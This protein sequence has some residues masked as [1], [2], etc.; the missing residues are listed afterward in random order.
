MPHGRGR[1]RNNTFPWDDIKNAYMLGEPSGVIADR[2]PGLKPGTIRSRASR[3]SWPTPRNI[4]TKLAEQTNRVR[5]AELRGD[6]SKVEAD[7]QLSDIDK[8]AESIAEKQASHAEVIQEI[9]KK[10]FQ[11]HKLPPIKTWKDA[12]IADDMARRALEM[13]KENRDTIVNVGILHGNGVSDDMETFTT[14]SSEEAQPASGVIV[15]TR[16][17]S[18]AGD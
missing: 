11:K 7:K 14:A 5:A 9:T 2:Y 12:K 13:D 3:E 17:A 4:S 10:K 1:P 16:N 6:I 18:E 15:D 8:V